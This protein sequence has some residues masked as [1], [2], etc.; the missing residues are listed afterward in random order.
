MADAL[1]SN[2]SLGLRVPAP[3]RNCALGRDD[4][5]KGLRGPSIRNRHVSDK[6]GLAHL[7]PGKRRALLEP[8]ARSG[9]TPQGLAPRVL[10]RPSQ[11]LVVMISSEIVACVE[12]EAMAVGITHI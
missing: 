10:Q 5:G 12:L 8:G 6:R 1:R 9:R 2:R 11:R 3:V 4:V 7:L